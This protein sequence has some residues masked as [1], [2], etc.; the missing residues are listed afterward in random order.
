MSPFAIPTREVEGTEGNVVV[1]TLFDGVVSFREDG[2]KGDVTGYEVT[3]S[4]GGA[5]PSGGS[6][7]RTLHVVQRARPPHTD[8]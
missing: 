1:P 6:Q 8:G 5:S 4:P 7:I 2:L 3:A